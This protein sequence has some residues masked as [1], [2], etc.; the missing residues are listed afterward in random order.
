MSQAIRSRK[1]IPKQYRWDLGDIIK[2]K[3]ALKAFEK[4]LVESIAGVAA[5]QGE[6]KKNPIHAVFASFD[7]S[8]RVGTYLTFSR[9]QLDQDGAN[10]AY[11][12]QMARAEALAVKARAAGA[13]LEPEL[14]ALPQETLEA[15]RNDKDHPQFSVFFHDLLRSREHILSREQEEMLAQ[16]GE[17]F[18]TASRAFNV[19]N[20]VDLPLPETLDEQ[21]KTSRLTH[22]GYNLRLRSK[23]RAVR[24]AAFEGMQNT[25]K[26]F[27]GT[28]STLY[29]GSV[30]NDVLQ[31][32]LR[33]Y[34]SARQASLDAH[35][36]PLS[37]YDGLL[38]EAHRAFPILDRYL[39]L[40]RKALKLEKLHLY[41]LYVP[42]AAD[43]S[44]D[45]PYDEAKKLVKKGLRPLG[46][47]YAKLLD[48]AYSERWIDVYETPGKRSGAYS[49]GTYDSH[50]YVLLNHTDTI[51]GAMTLAHELGH[52][53]HSYFSNH[54]Q[55]YEKSGYSLFAAEVASTCNEILVSRALQ[56]EYRDN[57]QARL[58]FLNDLAE[59]FRT[60]FFRQTLF[61]E[62]EHEAH[63]MAEAGTALTDEALSDLY[64]KLYRKYYGRECVIDP[65]IRYEWMRIPHFYRAF[66]VYQYATGFS[67]AVYLASRILGGGRKATERYFDFLSAGGSLPPIDALRAAGADM[68]RPA[69]IRGAM[70][71]F[72]ET[73]AQMESLL[74]P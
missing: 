35:E 42:I 45:L 59:G 9:M 54:A 51:D 49:W 56:E 44:L 12:A 41:D 3:K 17:V 69:V 64:E 26:A 20:N 22:A 52:A 16:A 15:L 60:T 5:Y 55:P 10:T 29:I 7:L 14:L 72:E 27:K 73:V 38:R 33:K 40:R 1:D 50:P 58:F 46:P 11:K 8:R 13:Y 36:I 6:V 53:M 19:F 32:R 66:Y 74:T 39:R 57:P 61:A 67:A 23:D 65:E 24:K 43:F 21:G 25:F 18:H 34:G 30:K 47:D 31:A 2:S 4:D 71:V 63:R 70:K 37:V 28:V 68:S 48:R 62:F